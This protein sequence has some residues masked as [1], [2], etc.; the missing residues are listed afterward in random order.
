MSETVLDRLVARIEA[1]LDFNANA[2]VKPWAL[3]WPDETAQWRL[4]IKRVAERLPVV[5][6]GEYDVERRQ[7]PAYW[8]RC[9][10]AGTIEIGLPDDAPIV[11]LPGVPRAELR[12]VESCPPELAPIAELQ[13]RSNEFTQPKS[14]REWSIRAFLVNA[15]RGLGLTVAD[16]ADTAAAMLLALDRFLDEPFDRVFKQVLDADYFNQLVNPD[17]T[18]ILFGWLDDPAG[19]RSR[20]DDAQWTAFEKQCAADW[21]FRP[22]SDGPVTAARRLGERRGKWADVWKRFADMPER[23]PGIVERLRQAK[24]MELSFEHSDAWPQ[25]NEAAEDHLRNLLRDF[26][27]LTAE[28]ARKEAARLD[29]EHAPRRRTVWAHLGLAPLA[30]AVEQLGLLAER[31]ASE[32]SAGGLDALALEYTEHGWQADDAALRALAAASSAADRAAV[33]AAVTS[34][35]RPWLDAVASRFQAAIG[36]MAHAGTYHPGPPASTAAGTATLFVDGLRLDVAHRLAHRLAGASLGVELDTS[37]AALPTVTETAKPAL[38]PVQS[39]ALTAGPGLHPANAITGTK[40]SIQVLRSLMI[41]KGVQVLGPTESGD[42][43]GVAWTEAGEVDHRGHDVGARLVDY[44]DEEVGRIASRIRE[45]LDSSWKRVD[46][47][48]DHGWILLPVE[49]EKVDLPVA[50]TEIK[51][52]R[53]ARI[54]DGAAVHVPTVPWFWDQDVRIALAPGATCFEAGTQYEH[55]GASPQECIVPRLRVTAGAAGAP[56][57]APEII[58]ITW[59]GLLCRI[60][61]SGLAPGL[62]VD[63]R[64]MP[65]DAKTSIAEKAKETSGA[66]KVSLLVSDEELEG[67]RAHL[68]L[69]ASDGQILAQREVV[70]GKNR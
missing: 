23:Y 6:L 43:S 41:D 12:A 67:Q 63:L 52:G 62:M 35:Y 26:E 30:F 66:E 47:V 51:K 17:P 56:T 61:L 29:A 68:V 10:V 36:P 3:L 64:A 53:C 57:T 31:T 25:D 49:M 37:L 34:M 14:K 22:S 19:Y 44:L 59:L 33:T 65:A 11:Y 16:G 7:G 27:A 42:P 50:T 69:V 32:P 24:P 5:T 70:V 45:L 15:D 54:K 55:G 20:L 58:K 9:V 21:G 28:G 8:V 40:A 4:V 13:Y 1:A 38:V 2:L 18:S 48:T 39:D 60:E 46:V